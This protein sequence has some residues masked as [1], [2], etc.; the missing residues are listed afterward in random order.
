MC[1]PNVFNYLS[2]FYEFKLNNNSEVSYLFFLHAI[3]KINIHLIRSVEIYMEYIIANMFTNLVNYY[4]KLKIVH[5]QTMTCITSN[6][7]L[8]VYK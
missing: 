6:N 3:T 8:H 7:N 5:F 1:L 4:F 2:I